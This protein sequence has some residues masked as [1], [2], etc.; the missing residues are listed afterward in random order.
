MKLGQIEHN[1]C[2]VWLRFDK[3][4]P[5]HSPPIFTHACKWPAHGKQPCLFRASRTVVRLCGGII[6]LL[7]MCPSSPLFRRQLLVPGGIQCHLSPLFF[8]EHSMQTEWIRHTLLKVMDSMQ[9]LP[10][11]TVMSILSKLH[12]WTRRKEMTFGH[13]TIASVSWMPLETKQNVRKRLPEIH[14]F[15]CILSSRTFCLLNAVYLW[16]GL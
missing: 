15:L 14:V 4:K 6:A 16:M 2:R 9:P 8:R 12:E 11:F 1:A 5:P 7:N 3:P 10:P 13:V